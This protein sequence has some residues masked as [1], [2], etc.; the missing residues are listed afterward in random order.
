MFKS[1]NLELWLK[2]GEDDGPLLAPIYGM[3]SK[4][5]S[6]LAATHRIGIVQNTPE[7]I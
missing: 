6:Y 5:T 2:E 1:V 4:A 7:Q 3:S